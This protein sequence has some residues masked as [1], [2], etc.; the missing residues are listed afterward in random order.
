[1]Q[2]K[3]F[4]AAAGWISA[5]VEIAVQPVRAQSGAN[6]SALPP[7]ELTIARCAQT[8]VIDGKLD[9]PCWQTAAGV[10]NLFIL[11]AGAKTTD[12]H[13][14]LLAYDAEWLYV[15]F[16]VAHNR[17]EFIKPAAEKRD[18]LVQR[19]NCVK[20]AF[21]PGTGARCWYHIRLS[22]GN[23]VSDQRNTPGGYSGE[24]DLPL[25]SAARIGT[26]GWQAE[27]AL[28]F[29]EMI[30]DGDLAQARL[31]LLVYTFEPVLDEQ[32]VIVG[33]NIERCSWAPVDWA[34]WTEPLRF[35][36]IHGL[37][38][39]A[40]KA[41]FLPM[42]RN[43]RIAP[44]YMKDGKYYYDVIADFQTLS[45]RSGAVRVTVAD[46][47]ESGAAVQTS[48]DL[49]LD[50]SADVS[51]TL[52][53][54]VK[55][56]VKRRAR[57]TMSD[58]A[59]GETLQSE[60][61]ADTSSLDLFSAYLDRSYYTDEANAFAV[62]KIGLPAGGFDGIAL[63]AR[64]ADG[65]VM[66]ETS[67]VGAETRLPVPIRKLAAGRHDLAI[68]LRA[69]GGELM[70]S[71]AVTLTRKPPKPGC[72]VKIDREHR[73]LLKD[74]KPFFPYGFCLSGIRP[75]ETNVFH[76]V[77]AAGF[78]SV[79]HWYQMKDAELELPA[80]MEIAARHGLQVVLWP[81]RYSQGVTLTNPASYMQEPLLSEMVKFTEKHGPV[82][83]LRE[84]PQFA[85]L[86]REQ[87]TKIF[88][89]AIGQNLPRYLSVLRLAQNHPNLLAY[90][91]FDEP[92]FSGLDQWIAGRMLYAAY[93]KADG[94]HPLY[95]N[96]SSHIPEGKEA[97]DWMDILCTDPY[98]IP[99]GVK[100]RGNINWVSWV[101]HNTRQR[102]DSMRNVTW[103]IPMAEYWSGSWRRLIQPEEQR[104]QT[105]LALIHGARG[106]YYYLLPCHQGTW[107]ALRHLAVEM[108]TLGPAA[109]MPDAP[110]AVRYH[111]DPD[112]YDF[113]RGVFPDVQAALFANPSG[114]YVLMAANSQW[115]PVD[116]EFKISLLEDEKTGAIGRLFGDEKYPVKAGTFSERLEPFATRAYVIPGPDRLVSPARIDISMAPHPDVAHPE[117][118]TVTRFDGK[119]KNL[120][121]N[122]SFEDAA[123]SN[124]PDYYK[125]WNWP[126]P[127]PGA[128]INGPAARISLDTNVF[129]QGRQALKLSVQGRQNAGVYIE[130]GQSHISDRYLGNP[131][132]EFVFSAWLKGDRDGVK[133]RF[134]ANHTGARDT[135]VAVTREWKRYAWP[136]KL[137]A[138]IW[139]IVNHEAAADGG[140]TVWLDALQL[141]KGTEP[142][143]FVGFDSK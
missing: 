38:N 5:A 93:N 103:I 44:Y 42:F 137:P 21:D 59:T 68:E 86:S 66:A 25:R 116:A 75:G 19:E 83:D 95:S 105:Y 35:G 50:G 140:G 102:A 125:P 65:V 94:Y 113:D 90:M 123:V 6:V 101:T 55:A 30:T 11:G 71:Q 141:E 62:C 52:P 76:A 87:A 57:L 142:T 132:T 48:R 40:F 56:L 115:Y 3:R 73:I 63:Q 126:N 89:D 8:P 81:D 37:A 108:Q 100:P 128:L 109:L 129:Y 80:Y 82:K 91:I 64:N 45:S 20:V 61:I 31:N 2:Y 1:M 46:R 7:P 10:S 84:Y 136:L 107:D 121:A 28:P 33:E 138:R 88:N 23:V 4:L 34:W 119:H 97:L 96:Y 143:E 72:E 49:E 77:A 9:D 110:Q 139:L 13:R 70:S 22:A 67:Q 120:I 18:G 118:P 133:L 114:G 134:G 29:S 104:C 127:F 130:E 60:P 36:R 41:P 53:V 106:I 111:P 32:S 17:P 135:E 43:Q 124:F 39:A 47:P 112:Q 85:S 15:A 26:Q 79:L 12:R 69:P 122:P 78:N 99:G 24:W 16:D 92:F 131:N 98:W 27:L 117:A 14:V 51:L 54:P 74:G 58:P